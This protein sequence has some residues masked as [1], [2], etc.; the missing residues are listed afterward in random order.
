MVVRSFEGYSGADPRAAGSRKNTLPTA[1]SRGKGVK[2]TYFDSV[3][4]GAGSPVLN[5]N[6]TLA[7][8]GDTRR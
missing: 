2:K 3:G 4:A 6:G 1:G 7:P 5:F 8:A